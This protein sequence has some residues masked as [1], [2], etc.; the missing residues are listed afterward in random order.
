MTLVAAVLRA[1][2]AIRFP[3]RRVDALPASVLRL[4]M[5]GARTAWSSSVI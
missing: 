5:P 1:A 4:V 2:K 3:E